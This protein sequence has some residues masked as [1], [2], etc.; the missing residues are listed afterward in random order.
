MAEMPIFQEQ[1]NQ[2]QENKILTNPNVTLSSR[3]CH[4]D[5]GGG[6]GR[7]GKWDIVLC[8]DTLGFVLYLKSGWVQKHTHTQLG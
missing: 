6:G 3:S 1:L 5:H 4:L 7:V 8:I 2:Q